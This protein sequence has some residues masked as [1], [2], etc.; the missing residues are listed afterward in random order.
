MSQHFTH[1]CL[2]CGG[3]TP[4]GA[5]GGPTFQSDGKCARCGSE[6]I[7]PLAS[8]KSPD[9]RTREEDL[10]IRIESLAALHEEI[11]RNLETQMAAKDARIRQLEWRV[12]VLEVAR[13]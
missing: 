5:T 7:L 6:S 10:T 13:R 4:S 11:V 3:D 9:T 2:N 1:W 12:R 8:D